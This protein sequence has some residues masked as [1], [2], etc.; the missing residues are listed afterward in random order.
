MKLP[1]RPSWARPAQGATIVRTADGM[2]HHPTCVAGE[3]PQRGGAGG[4]IRLSSRKKSLSVVNTTVES[5]P[6]VLR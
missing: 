4:S 6:R 2:H 1:K 5:L 3:P